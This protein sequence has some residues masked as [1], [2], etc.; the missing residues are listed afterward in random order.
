M[1]KEVG[2]I[3]MRKL[4]GSEKEDWDQRKRGGRTKERTKEEG[5]K[6]QAEKF[7][8]KSIS[9]CEIMTTQYHMHKWWFKNFFM[10]AHVPCSVSEVWTQFVF[11]CQVMN[12]ARIHDKLKL[13]SFWERRIVQHSE[14]MLEE[15]NR[16]RSSSLTRSA[17]NL[18]S[19]D[20][21]H[22]KYAMYIESS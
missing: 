20:S 11:F 16:M 8:S 14:Q 2:A 3:E 5:K 21:L 15:E 10:E 17:V 4:L 18:I 13:R 19:E 9:V 12:A 1:W 7:H 6:T 22:F